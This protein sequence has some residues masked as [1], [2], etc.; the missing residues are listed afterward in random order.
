MNHQNRSGALPWT[1]LIGG[2]ALGALAMYLTDP[3]QG[4]RRRAL[5]QD[6]MTSATHR[7]SQLMSQTLRDTRNRLAGLQAEARRIITSSQAKPIDDH[8]LEA[9]VRSRLGRVIPHLQGVEVT[10]EQGRVILSGD[11][12]QEDENRLI[13]AAEAIPGVEGV[14]CNLRWRES[15]HRSALG[16]TI[17][18]RRVS[19]M[20]GTMGL[21]LLAWYGLRTYLVRSMSRRQ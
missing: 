1:S 12:A 21:G 3:V 19:W 10:T 8:V 2:L 4:R 5:L 18:R 14:R 11:I 7:T 16:A 13:E 9:R 15:P 6:K 17:S 20:A